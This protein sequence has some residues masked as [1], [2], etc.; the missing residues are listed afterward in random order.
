[1][2]DVSHGSQ[3]RGFDMT[4]H[5]YWIRHPWDGSDVT[6]AVRFDLDPEE[7]ALQPI[8]IE[9]LWGIPSDYPARLRQTLSRPNLQIRRDT[10]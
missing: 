8:V 10:D 4:G 3:G 2:I 7:R 1:V 9:S 6:L 5:R